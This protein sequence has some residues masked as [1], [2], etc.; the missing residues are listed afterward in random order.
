LPNIN[1]SMMRQ[2]QGM[3][4]LSTFSVGGVRNGCVSKPSSEYQLE[5]K[6]GPAAAVIPAPAVYTNTA[7][8]KKLVVECRVAGA[9]RLGPVGRTLACC[10]R[11]RLGP[12]GLPQG[13]HS[14]PAARLDRGTMSFRKSPSLVTRGTSHRTLAQMRSGLPRGSRPVGRPW[15]L[16]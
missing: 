8:V 2:Q 14:I 10:P 6:S 12:S 3:A 4:T 11:S 1:T 7:A 13:L 9:G 5:G 15:Q 16:P